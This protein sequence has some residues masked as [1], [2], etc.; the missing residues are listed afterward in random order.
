MNDTE[1][2][3]DTEIVND[4]MQGRRRNVLTYDV[5]ELE[6][7]GSVA[8]YSDFPQELAQKRAQ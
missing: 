7:R 6:R 8:S 5:N 4:K 2:L 1:I 3:N